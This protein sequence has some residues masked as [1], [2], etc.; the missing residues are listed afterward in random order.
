MTLS[1]K[2]DLRKVKLNQHAKGLDQSIFHHY[3][4]CPMAAADTAVPMRVLHVCR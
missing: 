4:V 2:S 3:L 1:S